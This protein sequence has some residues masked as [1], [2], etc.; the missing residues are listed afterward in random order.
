MTDGFRCSYCWKFI[1]KQD[2]WGY[3]FRIQELKPS[4][5]RLYLMDKWE[6]VDQICYDCHQKWLEFMYTLRKSDHNGK[7]I[8]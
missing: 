8:E 7:I 3:K 4:L 6:T 1:P 2:M 5:A